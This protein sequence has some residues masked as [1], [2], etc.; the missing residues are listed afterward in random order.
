[1]AGTS[2]KGKINRKQEDA[3][4]KR[5]GDRKEQSFLPDFGSTRTR[6]AYRRSIL[7]EMQ[8]STD[9]S[10]PE[11]P[12]RS[13]RKTYSASRVFKLRVNSS[14]FCEFDIYCEG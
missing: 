4:W 9:Q 14:I 11:A 6:E 2:P 10:V 1:M 12:P 5:R 3:E 7:G 8:E 13:K